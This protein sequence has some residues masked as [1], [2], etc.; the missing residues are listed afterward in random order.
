MLRRYRDYRS[1]DTLYRHPDERLLR[2]I[3]GYGDTY[4]HYYD[5]P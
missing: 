1:N 4:W 5:E 3:E 2:T